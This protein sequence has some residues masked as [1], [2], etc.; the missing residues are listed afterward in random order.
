GEHGPGHRGPGHRVLLGLGGGPGGTYPGADQVLGVFDRLEHVRRLDRNS[1]VDP[2][3]ELGER[4][5]HT[6][7]SKGTVVMPAHTVRHYE[8]RWT[9]QHG[10]L[11]DRTAATVVADCT[12]ERLHPMP[13][14]LPALWG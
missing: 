9:G 6:V 1:R 10:V 5:H 4:A 11:I 8:N 13:L 12:P 2:V 3:G 14:C 7:R